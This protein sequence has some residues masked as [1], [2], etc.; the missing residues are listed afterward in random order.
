VAVDAQRSLHGDWCVELFH[1]TS[2]H[3]IQA[4]PFEIV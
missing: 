4:L 3:T 1:L 2:P